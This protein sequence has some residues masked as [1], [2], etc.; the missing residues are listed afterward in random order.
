MKRDLETVAK[1]PKTVLV[2]VLDLA[3][4]IVVDARE[5]DEER[6]ESTAKDLG[7]DKSVVTGGIRIFQNL[8]G[9]FLT[10]PSAEK[11]QEELGTLGL[12]AEHA[13]IVKDAF[14]GSKPQLKILT[15]DIFRQRF[16]PVI[17][18]I[19]WRVDRVASSSDPVELA[20][21]GVVAFT[22]ETAHDMFD[23]TFEVDLEVLDQLLER[24]TTLRR[25]LTR[26]TKGS[27]K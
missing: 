19:R 22:L 3:K 18:E 9:P 11:F 26:A 16:G 24:L 21:I 13:R 1:T 14:L 4:E 27:T 5:V 25:E 15:K 8:I 7:V 17:S 2:K 12:D 23:Q 20:P 6:V 10:E